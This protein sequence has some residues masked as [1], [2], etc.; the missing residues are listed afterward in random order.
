[1]QVIKHSSKKL[2]RLGVPCLTKPMENDKENLPPIQSKKKERAQINSQSL[3]EAARKGF[4]PKGKALLLHQQYCSVSQAT[5]CF[6]AH[7]C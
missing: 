6:S 1:M 4:L 3:Q 5:N 2:K 7:L